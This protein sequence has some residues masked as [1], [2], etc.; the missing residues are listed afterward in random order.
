MCIPKP[1][2]ARAA[3]SLI[4]LLVVISIIAV[5]AA[6]LLPAITTVR[7]AVYGTQCASN[8]RQLGL[9]AMTY[10]SDHNGLFPPSALRKAD[11]VTFDFTHGWAYNAEFV[12]SYLEVEPDDVGAACLPGNMLC[13]SRQTKSRQIQLSYGLNRSAP[14]HSPAANSLAQSNAGQ[15]RSRVMIFA[16]ALDWLIL[17]TSATSWSAGF[18][19]TKVN[20][21]ISYR[22]QG[23]AQMVCFDGSVQRAAMPELLTLNRWK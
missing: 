7:R 22:H 1:A 9:A 11:G 18:E 5:L 6:M 17:S 19:G 20:A 4:E 8:L 2:T 16:D 10:A 13:P 15:A 21:A 23:Y 14:G 12:R 3:F